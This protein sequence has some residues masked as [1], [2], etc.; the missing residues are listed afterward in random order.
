MKFFTQIL[1]KTQN[2]RQLVFAILGVLLG[3]LL[4]IIPVQLFTDFKYLITDSEQAIGTQFL[5]IN[6]KVS[7]LNTLK[8]GES[9]FSESEIEELKSSP[10]FKKVGRFTSN[11]FEATAVIE[12][13]MNS[14]TAQ[15]RTELFLESVEDGF[16]DV[17]PSDW[18]WNEI[19]SDVPIILPNDF[20]NLYNF[21]FAPGR[22]LPQI[23]KGTIKMAHFQIQINGA[24]GNGVFTGKIAGFSN[25]ISSVLVPK[26]F[27][28]F[29]NK[30][31]GN[32]SQNDQSYRVIVE[33]K[34][35]SLNHL[36][37]YFKEKGYEVNTELL[38]NGKFSN[39][40]E[41]ILTIVAL[42]GLLIILVSVSAFVLYFEL[43][44]IRSKYELEVLLKLGYPHRKILSWYAKSIA[45]VLVLVFAING[46][47]LIWVKYQV[48]LY[49]Q[50]FGF[51]IPAGVHPW[52]LFLGGIIMGV[53]WLVQWFIIRNQVYQ[54]ALP[55]R[56]K[57]SN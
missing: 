40:I 42:L 7:V 48:N 34:S 12:V 52:V 3:F 13:P 16:L 2:F 35:N 10:N 6:K 14:S 24:S 54:L 8:L 53:V 28:D 23:S 41:A 32:H 1:V 56:I 38:K 21:N 26:A 9:T 45:V 51:E 30:K 15:M 25:R 39:L 22:G 50:N 36:H 19:S 33:A 44:I 46:M 49:I 17:K 20:I 27:M 55:I 57:I 11:D 47:L 5:V 4:V 18:S 43:A 37:E 31:F 29:T